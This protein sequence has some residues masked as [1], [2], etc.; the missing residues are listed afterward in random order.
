MIKVRQLLAISFSV[1][2]IGCGSHQ[3]IEKPVVVT[4]PEIRDSVI[5]LKD[6]VFVQDS[7]WFGEVKDSLGKVIGDLTVYYQKKIA[8]LKLKERIDTVYKEVIIEKPST[9][10]QLQT[11]IVDSLN[12]YERIIYYA[13][14]GLTLGIILYLKKKKIKL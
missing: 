9:S 10:D 8:D 14:I 6:T 5:I 11:I 7:V 4:V 3:V 12:W 13:A 1:I 2:L